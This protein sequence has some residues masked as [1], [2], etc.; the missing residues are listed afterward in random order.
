MNGLSS[1][2]ADFI[3]TT[4]YDQLKPKVIQQAKKVI[5]DTVGVS[6]AGYKLMEFP[7]MVIDLYICI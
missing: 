7:R 3:L 6:L 1:S 5:L 2:Y 4:H